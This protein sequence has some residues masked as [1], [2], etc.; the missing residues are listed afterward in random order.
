MCSRDWRTIWIFTYGFSLLELLCQCCI[1]VGV[2]GFC[3]ATDG[4]S[5]LKWTVKRSK[6]DYNLMIETIC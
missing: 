3:C 2:K 4:N 6:T 1:S 5:V